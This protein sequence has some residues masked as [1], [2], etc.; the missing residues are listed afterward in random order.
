MAAVPR[1]GDDSRPRVGWIGLGSM[2]QGMSLNLQRQLAKNGSPNLRYYN[3]TMSRGAP[4]QEIGGSPAS[5]IADLVAHSDIIFTSLSDDAAVLSTVSAIIGE[6]RSSGLSGKII[7]DTTT[8][9]PTTTATVQK[10]LLEKGA[11]FVAAP[12]FGASPVAAQGKL[13]WI[14]AGPEKP[15]QAITPLITGVMGRA[16]IRL[17]E[18]VKQASLMKTAGNFVTAG[19]MEIVA[20]AHVFA[21][22]TG[23]GTEAMESLL[24][25]QY[26][27]LALSMSKRLTTGVYMPPRDERPFSD[28]TLALK[29]VGHGISVAEEAGTKLQVAEVALGHLEEAARYGETEK[30]ALDSSS[31]Y[32]VLRKHADLPFETDL[33]RKRDA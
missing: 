11:S 21:E 15:V 23:L 10:L 4:L 17:G 24:E 25:Q 1:T 31:L 6:E 8:V 16:I 33:V 7:V 2:G 26:G 5:S 9:H 19:M 13:L 3:R 14:L 20:E 18:D 22:K 28:L 29:D 32:G 12:V 30:R 27:P